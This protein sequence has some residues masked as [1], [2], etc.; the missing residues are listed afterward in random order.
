[1]LA[2][3]VLLGAATDTY[4][5]ETIRRGRRGTTM[6]G[7]AT[8]SPTRP[9]LADAEIEAIVAYLRTMQGGS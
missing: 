3:P 5:V 7:F 9:A 8:P 1:M 4:L 2:N 6:E